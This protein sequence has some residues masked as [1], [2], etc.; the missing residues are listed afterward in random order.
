METVLI[1]GGGVFGLSTALA[2]SKRYP[3]SAITVVDRHEPPVP[4]GTSVDTTRVIRADYHDEA[5]SELALQAQKL[6]Q[7][8]PELSPH[9]YCSGMIYA[10]AGQGH[11]GAE[12]WE[13]EYAAAKELESK[14]IG[15]GD[16][17]S[18]GYLK[19]LGSHG[20]IFQRVNGVEHK[21]HPGEKQWNEGYLNEDV[22]FVNAEECMRVYYQKCKRQKNISFLFGNPVHRLLIANGTA[23]GVQLADGSNLNAS[24][25]VVAAGAWTNTL[26]DISDQ[27]TSTG[28]EV[29]WIKV[30]PSLEERYRGMPI[31]TNFST[32]FNIFPPLN[33]EIKC[34]RRSPGYTNTRYN[35]DSLGTRSE[36]SA[37]PDLP[38]SIPADAEQGLRENL[39]ELFPRLA[40]ATFARTKLCWFTNTPTSDF[41]IDRHP[42]IGNLALATG[43]SAHGWKF[44]C[45]LGDKIVDMLEGNLEPK[46]QKRWKWKGPDDMQHNMEG[47]PRAQGAKQELKYCQPVSIV[48]AGVFGLS[49]A[50]HLAKAGYKDV[51]IF[52]YQEYD[53]NGYACSQGCNAASAD[54]NKILRASYGGRKIYQTLAFDAMKHWDE[55]NE[56]VK[57]AAD[58]P[59][60]VSNED[61]LWVQAGFLRL[62]DDG[63]DEDEHMT[64]RNF[65]SEIKSTQYRI[66]DAQ[67]QSEAAEDGIPRTKLDPFDRFARCLP[68]DGIL[69]ATGGYVL[70]SKACSWA[71][72]LC[73]QA[74]VKLRLGAPHKFISYTTCPS[75]GVITGLTTADGTHHRASLL[76]VAGGGYTPSLVPSASSFLETTAG[77]ILTVRLPRERQDLWNKYSSDNFPVWSWKMSSYDPQKGINVA[78]TSVGGLYGFPRTPD[79]TI[80][81]GFRGAKWTNFAFSAEENKKHSKTE[82]GVETADS[83]EQR[84]AHDNPDKLSYPTYPLTPQIPQRALAVIQSFIRTNMP[85]LLSLPIDTLRLCWYTDSVDNDFV[86]DYVPHVPGLMVAS[87]GSGHGFKF[88]PVLGSKVL[89]V[90]ERRET[91][92]TKAWKWRSDKMEE[93]ESNRNGL[94]EGPQ[95]WR[96]L[97]RQVMVGGWFDGDDGVTRKSE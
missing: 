23:H 91:E 80:K 36:V 30:P 16:V 95:G 81:F 22:A 47:A 37:P 20:D 5:Y 12:I 87:G 14:R 76:I 62:S 72:H 7:G 24:L 44:L 21:P 8:D 4:D 35:V 42:V 3:R 79:G 46:L 6:I 68:T 78:D 77:S 58:L 25:V 1:I 84:A 90:I 49:T 38:S 59:P 92:Y 34:L 40:D 65:P 89:D 88:L 10:V 50:L 86:I 57:S 82:T 45:V 69:D 31:T 96:T 61:K 93:E 48:G 83:P 2:L 15:N 13:K 85:D 17:P 70:A 28:H 32:G 43:G 39:A 63:L 52:D 64:Q 66:T 54:E 9:V 94:E 67:R 55:W 56:A 75:S 11:H 73:R 33:G 19:Y 74:G 26:L 18:N 71:L 51:T 53:K 29:A 41:L 60:N 97:D 27:I